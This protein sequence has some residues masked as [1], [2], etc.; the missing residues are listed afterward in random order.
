V[1]LLAALSVVLTCCT[2]LLLI[3]AAL[4]D[5]AARTV[6]NMLPAALLAIGICVRM[7]DHSLLPGL[8]VAAS[9]FSVLFVIWLMGAIGG[10]DVKLRS[11]SVLLIPP[12]WQ[13]EFSCFMRIL[14]AGGILALIYLSLRTV[15][16]RPAV[17]RSGGL[18]TRVMRAEAWR[19]SRKA[20]LPYAFAIA[21]GTIMTL[22]P[23]SLSGLR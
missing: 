20:P 5:L 22:L 11:A 17:A 1:N 8:I 9:A 4:H 12:H 14:L 10:G 15:V 13:A 19:I 7:I 21:G 6:P 18:A 2:V 3:W 16:S 23:C